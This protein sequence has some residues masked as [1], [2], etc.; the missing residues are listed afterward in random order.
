MT[1]EMLKF[2]CLT[3]RVVWAAFFS[4]FLCLTGFSEV[5]H[6][7]ST[8]TGA[9]DEATQTVEFEKRQG[10]QLFNQEI[11]D[12]EDISYTAIDPSS[13]VVAIG[14]KFILNLKKN[15]RAENTFEI[16]VLPGGELVLPYAGTIDAKGM[17]LAE[18]QQKAQ[19]MYRAVLEKYQASLL[20]AEPGVFSVSV[21]GGVE[22]PGY[23]SVNS[24]MRLSQLIA[25]TGGVTDYGAIRCI[26]VRENNNKTETFDLFEFYHTGDSSQNPVLNPEVSVFV[27]ALYGVVT[28]EGEVHTPGNYE[29]VEGETLSDL[30]SYS[31]GLTRKANPEKIS[32]RRLIHHAAGD[33]THE[34]KDIDWSRIQSGEEPPPELHDGDNVTVYSYSQTK[35][36]T[37]AV[38]GEV[39]MPG[40]YEVSEGMRVTDLLHIAG[41]PKASADMSEASL[42]TAG[43]GNKNIRKININTILADPA[44]PDNVILKT[45]DVLY[46]NPAVSE[47]GIISVKGSVRFPGNHR[48]MKG[49]TAYEAVQL[50]G[51]IDLSSPGDDTESED[52]ENG[53]TSLLNLRDSMVIRTNDDGS[54]KIIPL[55]LDKII[56]ENDMSCDFPV[57][58]GDRII[59]ASEPDSIYIFGQVSNPGEYEYEQNAGCADYAQ[60]AGLE[61][62]ADMGSAV[63][64]HSDGS[65]SPC[66]QNPIFP[67]DSIYIPESKPE[68]RMRAI[69]D[70]MGII[71]SMLLI[72]N[73]LK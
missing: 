11:Q 60:K 35:G 63:I 62:N 37:V 68:K 25:R 50:A 4:L 47:S 27:P 54:M 32:L 57:Q 52:A 39:R 31:N 38:R 53:E 55:R 40:L 12:I 19:D 43:G 73:V 13:Y 15:N 22:S 7:V 59:L 34:L 5:A 70:Y 28:I 45:D 66:G 29:I 6:G 21:I 65:M 14:D 69:R 33:K 71:S 67:G 51:G 20:L 23:Y 64:S 30:I 58:D 18:L 61:E 2:K 3:V 9:D 72:Y 41:G 49:E 48:L 42:L 1:H 8:V 36:G 17:I 16:E 56:Y 46:V 10:E 44:H 24:M 26:E